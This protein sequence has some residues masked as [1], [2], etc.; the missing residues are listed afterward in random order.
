METNSLKIQIN[1]KLKIFYTAL[2]RLKSRNKYNKSDLFTICTLDRI[3]DSI[4][5]IILLRENRLLLDATCICRIILEHIFL[6]GAIVSI[7]RKHAF[8]KSLNK[9][10]LKDTLKINKISYLTESYKKFGNERVF[11]KRIEGIIRKIMKNCE[12]EISGYEELSDLAFLS[13]IYVMYYTWL[14][15]K[16]HANSRSVQYKIKKKDKNTFVWKTDF[17]SE[18]IDE[19]LYNFLMI[20]N[21]IIK[22][23]FDKT[24]IEIEYPILLNNFKIE[25]IKMDKNK[26]DWDKLYNKIYSKN[27]SKSIKTCAGRRP[28]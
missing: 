27:A 7:K 16:L 10:Y 19:L 20:I 15:A 5:S 24:I 6:L 22:Y 11:K 1:S 18:G 25:T 28:S 21:S 17:N 23:K 3:Y 13:N 2:A 4:Q 12:N 26:F 8:L 14:S 9:S